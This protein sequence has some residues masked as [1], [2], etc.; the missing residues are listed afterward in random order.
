MVFITCYYCCL[1]NPPQ[2]LF[3]L[4]KGLC[5]PPFTTNHH[6]Y[7]YFNS[8]CKKWLPVLSH[9]KCATQWTTRDFVFHY[10]YIILAN[11]S[12]QLNRQLWMMDAG[13]KHIC[14]QPYNLSKI[15]NR[16][17][18]CIYSTHK[19]T[20]KN[21]NTPAVVLA[22]C[23]LVRRSLMEICPAV[24]NLFPADRIAAAPDCLCKEQ[25]WL[26]TSQPT[27]PA[28]FT[29]GKYCKPTQRPSHYCSSGTFSNSSDSVN[30][31]FVT[32]WVLLHFLSPL[33]KTIS[34]KLLSLGWTHLHC[35]LE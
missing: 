17:I 1:F 31:C 30:C 11:N 25:Q 15:S 18:Y 3:G 20:K 28:A 9:W 34:T 7:L 8:I 2:K 26:H 13:F 22:C 10:A 4:S 12:T 16:R 29:T 35:H 6:F 5:V 14:L 27:D 24:H 21:R 19:S 33:E 32:T 23:W